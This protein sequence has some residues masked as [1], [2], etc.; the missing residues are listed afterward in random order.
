LDQELGVCNDTA[1]QEKH[2]GKFHGVAFRSGGAER[3]RK[4]FTVYSAM[5]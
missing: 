4:G 5:V 3:P 2:G 1:E